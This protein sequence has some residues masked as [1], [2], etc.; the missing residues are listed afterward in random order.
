MPTIQTIIVGF[1]LIGLAQALQLVLPLDQTVV[2]VAFGSAPWACQW[3]SA[4]EEGWGACQGMA[5]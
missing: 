5:V 2:M 1:G 4:V 3:A